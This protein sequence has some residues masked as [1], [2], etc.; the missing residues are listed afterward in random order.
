MEPPGRPPVLTISATFDFIM[1]QY[2][3]SMGI[4][5]NFSPALLDAADS[6]SASSSL[7][8]NMPVLQTIVVSVRAICKF[9]PNKPNKDMSI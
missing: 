5:H 3:S 6:S 8:E 7:G 2:P 1:S 4:R 9:M